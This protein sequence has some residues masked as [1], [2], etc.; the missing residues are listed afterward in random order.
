MPSFLNKMQTIIIIKDKVV[1][2]TKLKWTKKSWKN[3][4]RW[5]KKEIFTRD[6]N[7]PKVG[8]SVKI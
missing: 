5:K 1:V 4:N 3:I 2:N 6:S 7:Q 8:I